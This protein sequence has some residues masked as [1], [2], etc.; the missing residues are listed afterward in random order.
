MFWLLLKNWKLFKIFFCC[1]LR[2]WASNRR[3]VLLHCRCNLFWYKESHLRAAGCNITAAV[4]PKGPRQRKRLIHWRNLIPSIFL[5]RLMLIALERKKLK[6]YYTSLEAPPG[7]GPGSSATILEHKM[8]NQENLRL[9]TR[10]VVCWAVLPPSPLMLL[11]ALQIT[12]PASPGVT[13]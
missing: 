1:L 2:K 5:Q 12:R 3:N 7:I 6:K 13:A 11:L 10:V 9:T 4:R 8:I